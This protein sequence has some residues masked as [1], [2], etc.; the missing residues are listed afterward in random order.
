MADVKITF[1][2]A[3]AGDWVGMYIDGKLVDE[4]HSIPPHR[5][6]NAMARC[7]EFQHEHIECSDK[8]FEESGGSMP[9]RLSEVIR[10]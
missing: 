3:E 8:T 2:S 7:F 6:L 1:V 9:K 5:I 4:G 10:G